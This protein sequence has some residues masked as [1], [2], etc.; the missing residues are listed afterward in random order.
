MHSPYWGILENGRQM[1][2]ATHQ[3]WSR[4]SAAF[5]SACLHNC[6]SACIHRYGGRYSCSSC[7]FWYQCQH[8]C[9]PLYNRCAHSDCPSWLS[10]ISVIFQAHLGGN[11]LMLSWLPSCITII[12][13]VTLNYSIQKHM[14]FRMPYILYAY[15]KSQF[16]SLVCGSIMLVPI[17]FILFYKVV[18]WYTYVP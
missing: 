3:P 10:C 9:C 1:G 18:V 17:N 13:M 11:Y 8:N 5:C 7:L 6:V 12:P 2:V 14:D 15:K 16:N 4:I